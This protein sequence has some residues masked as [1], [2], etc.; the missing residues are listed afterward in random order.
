MQ[1]TAQRR[2]APAE[3]MMLPTMTMGQAPRQ[4]Q[5]LR[6]SRQP[7]AE[8]RRK[9]TASERL[10]AAA[11]EA[12]RAHSKAQRASAL[13]QK[14]SRDIATPPAAAAAAPE[15]QSRVARADT[16]A[17]KRHERAEKLAVQALGIQ[18]GSSGALKRVSKKRRHAVNKE[19][20]IPEGVLAA[21]SEA[22]LTHS[23]SQHVGG[24]LLE[25]APKNTP[26]AGQG[27]LPSGA[28]CPSSQRTQQQDPMQ[29]IRCLLYDVVIAQCL[30][31]GKRSAVALKLRIVCYGRI[32]WGSCQ[33]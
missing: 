6:S 13:A 4:A 23:R 11:R 12:Q 20:I 33:T 31:S 21:A 18:H 28:S 3:V 14:R 26:S 22:H 32:C 29:V 16:A 2:Y 17:H 5:K 9:S 8:Q 15:R 25:H 30:S 24:A 1:T 19:N 7:R 10:R 27:G